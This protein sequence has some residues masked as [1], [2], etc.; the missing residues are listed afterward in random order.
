MVPIY[1][2]QWLLAFLSVSQSTDT[3]ESQ[4]QQIIRLRVAVIASKMQKQEE[5]YSG[6][7][8]GEHVRC[9]SSWAGTLH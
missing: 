3:S 1:S 8:Y 5:N 6:E 7:V 4:L 2:S 9:L